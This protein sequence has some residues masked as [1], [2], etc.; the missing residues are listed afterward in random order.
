MSETPQ[1]SGEEEDGD[2]LNRF[3]TIK[4]TLSLACAPKELSR[5]ATPS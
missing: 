1:P 2:E 5:Y 3:V 4:D